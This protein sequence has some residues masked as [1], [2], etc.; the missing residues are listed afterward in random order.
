MSYLGNGAGRQIIMPGQIASGA[1]G[2]AQQDSAAQVALTA[3]G[4]RNLLINPLFIIN[5][6]TYAGGNVSGANTYTWDRWRVVTSGQ[7]APVSGFVMTAPAGGVEQ[8]VEGL[9]IIGG[10]YVLSW[11]GTATA[12]YNGTSIT[13]GTPFSLTAGANCTIRF[14]GGTVSFPQLERGTVVTVFDQRAVVVE[15]AMCLRYFRVIKWQCGSVATA[16]N[17]DIYSSVNFDPMRSTATVTLA[18]GTYVNSTTP[19][20]YAVTNRVFTDFARSGGA[21]VVFAEYT[22]SLSAEL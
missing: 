4:M 9:S 21:G 10:Q 7:A 11:T 1:V 20:P 16:A 22:A 17:Q 14:T 8:V 18:S 2:Y 19:G 12:S 6:R 15:Q 13:S 3:G 5:Q